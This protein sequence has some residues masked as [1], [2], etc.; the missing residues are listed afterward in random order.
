M[1]EEVLVTENLTKNYG[2]TPA[3]DHVSMS[4]R[5]GDIY[6]FIGANG[7]GKTTFMRMICGLI[8][9]T[10]GGL[11]LYGAAGKKGLQDARKRMGALIEHPAIYP[12]MSAM[13][14]DRKSVV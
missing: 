5:R 11:E 3:V 4:V 6:G 10:E 12:N 7:A 14:K 2:R 9:P 1:K 13:E 8:K